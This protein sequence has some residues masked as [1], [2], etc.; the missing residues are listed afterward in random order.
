MEEKN[1]NLQP[2]NTDA[3]SQQAEETMPVQDNSAT[4]ETAAAPETPAQDTAESQPQPEQQEEK[5]AE[6]PFVEPQVDYSSYT[7][8][9][10]VDELRE[11]LQLDIPKIR[12]RVLAIKQQFAE[13]TAQLPA[14]EPDA[15]NQPTDPTAEAYEELYNQ[16][17]RKRQKHTKEPAAEKPTPRRTPRTHQQQRLPQGIA[18]QIQRNTGTLES[19]RRRA[20]QRDKQPMEQLPLPYRAVFHQS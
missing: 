19:H 3:L 6:E 15:D 17:R 8:E 20:P 16:Y 2:E 5:P 11:L 13:K 18:R 9:Q 12:N 4:T 14:P 10:L 7:R 1:Q